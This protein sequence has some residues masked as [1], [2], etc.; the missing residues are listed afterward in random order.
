[1]S[2][3]NRVEFRITWILTENVGKPLG[4]SSIHY[5]AMWVGSMTL[6]YVDYILW[7]SNKVI[8]FYLLFI[9]LG[10]RLTIL[11]GIKLPASFVGITVHPTIIH[12]KH[13]SSLY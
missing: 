4:H 13:C 2:T 5:S 7:A 9:H 3:C 8:I 12:M 11:D 1:M 6:E 10:R